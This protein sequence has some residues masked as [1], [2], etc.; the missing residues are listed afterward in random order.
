MMEFYFIINGFWQRCLSGCNNMK[1]AYK[2][3]IWKGI[4]ALI[5]SALKHKSQIHFSYTLVWTRDTDSASN[6]KN[7]A[8]ILSFIAKIMV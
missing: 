3:G 6:M 5:I 7:R 1:A 8:A 4:I 2:E